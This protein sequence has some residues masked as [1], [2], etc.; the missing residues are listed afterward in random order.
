M[1]N[2][3]LWYNKGWAS[4]IMV[5]PHHRHTQCALHKTLLKSPCSSL[6]SENSDPLFTIPASNYNTTFSLPPSPWPVQAGSWATGIISK[7]ILHIR[8]GYIEAIL[9]LSGKHQKLYLIQTHAQRHILRWQ[10]WVKVGSYQGF[11]W[12]IKKQ[13]LYENMKG[14]QIILVSTRVKLDDNK[15][16]CVSN[17][18]RSCTRQESSKYDTVS[19]ANMINSLIKLFY[20][21]HSSEQRSVS[22]LEPEHTTTE[23]Y[24]GFFMNIFVN[25]VYLCVVKHVT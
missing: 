3:L 12:P 9:C 16:P 25:K 6:C 17:R 15:W 19:T 21:K 22:L 2:T 14:W 11:M 5:L 4:L 23:E 7:T 8:H 24:T 10:N 1:S 18:R 20:W 13:I